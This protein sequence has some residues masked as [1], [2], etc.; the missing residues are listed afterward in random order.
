MQPISVRLPAPNLIIHT[1][2][3]RKQKRHHN[4]VEKAITQTSV[5]VVY[6]AVV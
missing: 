3:A 5:P 4:D 2:A 6:S 1:W